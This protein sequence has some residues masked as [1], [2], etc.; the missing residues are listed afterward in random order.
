MKT[1]LV[2]CAIAVTCVASAWADSADSNDAITKQVLDLERAALDGWK[3]GDPGPALNVLAPE[4]T[5]IHAAVGVRLDGLDAVRALFEQYRGRPLF[6]SYEIV[7]PKLQMA[8]DAAILSYVLVRHNGDS[9]SR[10]YGTEV[11]QRKANGWQVLHAH[12]S[13][14]RQLP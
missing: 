4:I 12:W 9:S 11:Y 3:K 1:A 8:G 10:W 7:D 6:D 14:D 5:Y 13:E 2:L